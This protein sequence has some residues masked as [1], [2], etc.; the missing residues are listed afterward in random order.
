M[1]ILLYYIICSKTFTLKVNLYDTV[2]KDHIFTTETLPFP[3]LN[4][5]LIQLYASIITQQ[6]EV[7]M[8]DHFGPRENLSR[9][10]VITQAGL[11][12]E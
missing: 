11:K 6:C 1:T 9:Q 7:R 2:Q 5:D 3:G 4:V 8:K 12:P 10:D